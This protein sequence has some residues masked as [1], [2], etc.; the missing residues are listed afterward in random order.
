MHTSAVTCLHLIRASKWWKCLPTTLR[1][2]FLGSDTKRP[3][4]VQGQMVL[5]KSWVVSFDWQSL[6]AP[7]PPSWSHWWLN[8][9]NRRDRVL[10]PLSGPNLGPITFSVCSNCGSTVDSAGEK[11]KVKAESKGSASIHLTGWVNGNKWLSFDRLYIHLFSVTT[12]KDTGAYLCCTP[13]K[14]KTEWCFRKREKENTIA[15]F[16]L[17]GPLSM[18]S[19]PSVASV[20][21]HSTPPPVVD[22]HS[23]R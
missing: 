17:L 19:C 21:A 18:K 13:D 22:Y 4:G 10:T 5:N 15:P 8:G 9:V 23:R 6:S 1:C 14:M 7:P 20:I 16:C 3:V 11:G 12:V 2:W